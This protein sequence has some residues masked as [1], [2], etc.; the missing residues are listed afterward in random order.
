MGYGQVGPGVEAASVESD[1][2]LAALVPRHIFSR[3]D[4]GGRVSPVSLAGNT[5]RVNVEIL[6][7]RIPPSDNGAACA[8]RYDSGVVLVSRGGAQCH[9]VCGPLW[10]AGGVYTLRVDVEILASRIPPRSLQP[11]G[12][13][14]CLNY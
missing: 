14:G 2:D 7:S 8:V 1:A 12:M 10:R 11:S 4:C 13:K 3:G 6:A 5:L 9:A